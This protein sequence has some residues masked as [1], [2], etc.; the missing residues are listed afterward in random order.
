MTDGHEV[1]TEEFI[2]R[3]GN[4]NQGFPDNFVAVGV[5]RVGD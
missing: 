4:I 2:M 1:S 5:A 3:A